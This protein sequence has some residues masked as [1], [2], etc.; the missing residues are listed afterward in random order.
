MA[1][2]GFAPSDDGRFLAYSTDS[3][4]YRQYTLHVKNLS[5]GALLPDQAERVGRVAWA[6]DN[7]TLF[8]TTEDAVT[9]RSDKFFRHELGS[10]RT[11]SFT[12]RRTS[13]LT[14]TWDERA[15]APSSCSRALRR[16]PR[17]AGICRRTSR[18]RRSRSSFRARRITSMTSTI[19]AA[20]FYIRTNKG[21]KNF[22]VVTAP[23][24]QPSE[25]HWTELVAH[26][27][28][29]KIQSIDPFADHLVLSEWENGLQQLEVVDLK[30][31]RAPPY[32]VSRAGICRV[33]RAKLCV[34]HRDAALQ[35][36]VTGL[37]A[38]RCS[39]TTWRRDVRRS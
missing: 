17:S 31:P 15:T 25:A 24:A 2:G 39:T 35:L 20:C 9:K 32:V 33:R 22:R 7:Q 8:F 27:P 19:A 28:E 38:R 11:I 34:R 16:L 36:P 30:T 6:T 26:R 23:V 29:V 10:T 12:K 1:L 21:A 18:P 14:S 4:G 5:T 3:T 37:A 13:S